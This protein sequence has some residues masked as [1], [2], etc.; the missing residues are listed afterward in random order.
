MTLDLFRFNNSLNFLT[1]KI[2]GGSRAIKNHNDLQ[3]IENEFKIV[4]SLMVCTGYIGDSL[5]QNAGDNFL[6]IHGSKSN[7]A[8]LSLNRKGNT[9]FQHR[10]G[11]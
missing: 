6:I 7:Y 3:K 4:G 8:L 2:D 10:G 5:A 9:Y 11:K 1:S